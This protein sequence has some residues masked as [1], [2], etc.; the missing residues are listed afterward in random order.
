MRVSSFF[1]SLFLLL[2]FLFLLVVSW[3]PDIF[4]QETAMGMILGGG[5]KLE[6]LEEVE[7]EEIVIRIYCMREEST[8]NKTNMNNKISGSRQACRAF[9]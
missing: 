5:S 3:R 4:S 7:G 9:S 6:G 8:F 2:L 1:Y